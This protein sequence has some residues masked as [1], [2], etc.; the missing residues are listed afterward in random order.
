V[1]AN[2][3]RLYAKI[4]RGLDREVARLRWLTDRAPVPDVVYW[5]RRDGLDLLVTRAVPGVSLLSE[6]FVGQ[7]EVAVRLL[8]QGL[9]EFHEI[10]TA[11][12][13]FGHWRPGAVVVH[14]DACL[15]NVLS[16]GVRVT[17]FVDLADVGLG[18]RMSDLAAAVW[19]I[20]YNFGDAFYG[21][22]FDVYGMALPPPA[23][24][25]RLR[26]SFSSL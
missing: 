7:P 24:I 8:A 17:G 5:D 11:D 1:T 16:D 4:G 2:G 9:R 22:F 21:L 25:Q 3:R 26:W 20:G 13:P 18:D 12:C 10:D 19:S 23:E 6:R 14:G 15:P